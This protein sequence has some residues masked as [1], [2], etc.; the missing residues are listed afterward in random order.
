MKISLEWIS[1]FVYIAD[2]KPEEVADRVTM[3]VA[4]VEEVTRRDTWVGGAQ[5]I[6]ET[7][8]DGFP[9]QGILCSAKELGMSSFHEVILEIPDSVGN[10]TP[11]SDL[12]PK[13]DCI[14]EIDNK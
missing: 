8:L 13:S 9:S 3:K 12:I 2:L 4:G 7:K 6:K 5:V 10:G 11:L 1:Q 14:I